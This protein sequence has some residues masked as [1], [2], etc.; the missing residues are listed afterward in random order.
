MTITSDNSNTSQPII[1]AISTRSH[2][3][4]I[5]MD[6]LWTDPSPEDYAAI[7]AE[8]WKLADDDVEVLHWGDENIH[9]VTGSD[10]RSEG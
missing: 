5:T 4:G 8:A 1:D 2:K 7:V 6:A 10:T 3:T 9:R